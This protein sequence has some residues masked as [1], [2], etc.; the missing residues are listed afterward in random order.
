MSL[1]IL[2]EATNTTD[3]N[4]EENPVDE[5]WNIE[6][7]DHEE[8]QSVLFIGLIL[9]AL[10]IYFIADGYFRRHKPAVGHPTGVVLIAGIVFSFIYYAAKGQTL[11]DN[12]EFQF[13][14]SIYWN[15]IIP[16][17]L[18]NFGYNMK[19]HEV[20]H[21]LGNVLFNGFAVTFACIALTTFGCWLVLQYGDHVMTRYT[22]DLDN[23][24]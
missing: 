19:R 16:S 1:R 11:K 3:W 10:I 9:A 22:N 2:S 7:E 17:I 6:D 13:R 5:E 4:I 18:F 14:P 23:S 24:K 21:S 8:H 15:L 20:Y 12:E